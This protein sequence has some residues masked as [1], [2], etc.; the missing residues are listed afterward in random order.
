[1]KHIHV[2]RLIAGAAVLHIAGMAALAADGY[3]MDIAV[4]PPQM[5]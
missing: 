2:A 3:V 4:P 1:M 5:S